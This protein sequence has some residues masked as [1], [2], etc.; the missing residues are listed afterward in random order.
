M[1]DFVA[2]RAH[3]NIALIKYWGKR[4]ASLILPT[5]ESLSLTLDPLYTDTAV[6]FIDGAEDQF[7]LDGAEQEVPRLSVSAH[8]LACSGNT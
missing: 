4:D 2:A 6:S 8:L 1:T 3:A 7:I 5:S